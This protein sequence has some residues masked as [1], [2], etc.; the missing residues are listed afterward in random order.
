MAT[1]ASRNEGFLTLLR[2]KNFLLLWLAQLISMTAFWAAN[3]GLIIL[4]KE[5]T[6]S[7]TLIGLAIIC[8]SLPAVI[9]GAPAGVF[10]DRRSKRRVLFY[11]NCLRAI[12]TLGFVVSLVINSGQLV[13]V[14]LLTL[15]ISGIGQFF[16]PAEGATIPMLVNDEELMPALSLFQITSMLSNALGFLVLAPLLLIFVPDIHIG[17]LIF[18]R[19]ESLYVILA[20]FYAICAALI[21]LIPAQNFIEPKPRK[22]TTTELTAESLGVLQNVWHEMLQA[23]TFIRRRPLLFEAV[24]QLSF[25]GILFAVIGQIAPSLVTDLLGLPATS[26]AF[27][28]APAGVGL[29]LGS[30]IMPRTT[31]FLGKERTILIGCIALTVLVALIPL[32]T[33]LAHHLEQQEIPVGA[34]HVIVVTLLMFLAGIALD[35][36]NIPANTTMQ[37]KTPDWIKGRVLALQL[38][39]FNGISIPVILLIGW[40]TDQFTLPVTLYFM[41][42]CIAAFGFWGMYYEHKSHPREHE[43]EDMDADLEQELEAEQIIR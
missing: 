8:A 4:I 40:I 17:S 10:V 38:A 36:I 41:A 26:M 21:V 3:Y 28:F 43:A 7:T 22:T 11:S 25:A 23:W 5:K 18:T 29:V 35:F 31:S 27:V 19:I 1:A 33:L 42:L 6:S 16:A 20:V 13:V 2:K 30:L 37:E 15:L 14:Y 12:A 39:F 9:I 34:L 32:S 24:I